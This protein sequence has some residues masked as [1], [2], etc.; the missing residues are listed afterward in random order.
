[1]DLKRSFKACS[2]SG[3]SESS[4][5]CTSFSTYKCKLGSSLTSDRGAHQKKSSELA[6]FTSIRN[7]THHI[8]SDVIG[9]V[10]VLNLRLGVC[11]MRVKAPTNIVFD[12]FQTSIFINVTSGATSFEYVLLSLDF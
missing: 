9:T 5:F 12:P 7:C 2:P 11:T 1:M 6:A 10:Y 4:S 8:K 3:F